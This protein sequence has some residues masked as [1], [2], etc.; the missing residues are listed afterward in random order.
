MDIWRL[1][2]CGVRGVAGMPWFLRDVAQEGGAYR[3][4]CTVS[5]PAC[6]QYRI[7]RQFLRAES[8]ER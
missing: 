7:I 6:Q 4:D 3:G 1:L 8:R 2:F 5:G